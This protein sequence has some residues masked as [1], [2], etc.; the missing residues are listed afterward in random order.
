MSSRDDERDDKRDEA[1]AALPLRPVFWCLGCGAAYLPPKAMTYGPGRPASPLHCGSERCRRACARVPA[2]V[3][4]LLAR[5][6]W[7]RARQ[8]AGREVAALPERARRRA[9]AGKGPG[10]ARSRLG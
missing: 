7:E 6:A 3:R 4:A 2:A 8:G 10:G 9:R 1:S 5:Q